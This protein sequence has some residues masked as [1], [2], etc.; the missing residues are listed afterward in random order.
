MTQTSHPQT[1]DRG[2][3]QPDPA[4]RARLTALYRTHGHDILAYALRR[5]PSPED[6]ADAV[7]ETFLVAW[8][9]LS[10][11]PAEPQARLWL[12]GVAHRVMLNLHRAERR[13]NRL[14]ERLGTELRTLATPPSPD[15]RA[16]ALLAALQ[17]LA[18]EDRE[19][20]LLVGW[21]ELSPAQAATVLGISAVAARVRLHRARRRLRR[22]LSDP[23]QA[24]PCPARR[25]AGTPTCEARMEEA[26]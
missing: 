1:A 14:A 7:A 10:E 13:R 18:P 5:A 11:V 3:L 16:R 2:A 9:R 22:A 20:L 6:A 4:A 23:E 15:D 26:L 17:T 24:A 21:E 8:R 19:L 12:Y 25:G